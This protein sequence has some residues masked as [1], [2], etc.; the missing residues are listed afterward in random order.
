MLLGCMQAG[1]AKSDD[2]DFNILSS[3]KECIKK[4]EEIAHQVQVLFTKIETAEDLSQ[5]KPCEKRSQSIN[6]LKK[7]HISEVYLKGFARCQPLKC[8]TTNC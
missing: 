7:I 1:P 3:P 8:S 2:E 4:W 5:E 6:Q